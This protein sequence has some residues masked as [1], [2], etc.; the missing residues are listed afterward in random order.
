MMKHKETKRMSHILSIAP[1]Q[2][3]SICAE[4]Q[5]SVLLKTYSKG[6]YTVICKQCGWCGT[7]LLVELFDLPEYCP[8]CE[9][10]TEEDYATTNIEETDQLYFSGPHGLPS[11]E[12]KEAK[13]FNDKMLVDGQVDFL[14]LFFDQEQYWA[15]LSVLFGDDWSEFIDLLSQPLDYELA[16]EQL[17]QGYIQNIGISAGYRTVYWDALMSVT[18]ICQ[19]NCKGRSYRALE[20]GYSLISDALEH[21]IAKQF[22]LNDTSDIGLVYAETT[23][24]M[25]V[26]EFQSYSNPQQK[27]AMAFGIYTSIICWYRYGVQIPIYKQN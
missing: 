6:S 9:V 14:R 15:G 13:V 8:R 18:F 10:A 12:M 11:E 26:R 1:E 16:F 21:K 25:M 27:H 5:S 19:M 23:L 3:S 24:Y 20:R 4:P 7:H 2:V 17:A 22:L